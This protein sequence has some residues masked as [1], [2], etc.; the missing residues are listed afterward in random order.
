MSLKQS[1]KDLYVPGGAFIIRVFITS[2]GIVNKVAAA[3]IFKRKTSELISFE[4]YLTSN[5][6]WG[7]MCNNIIFEITGG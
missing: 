2:N 5:K 4:K 7:K 6:T 1:T 3:P